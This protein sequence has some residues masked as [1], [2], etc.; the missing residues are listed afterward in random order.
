MPKKKNVDLEKQ[1]TL[2]MAQSLYD[3]L[4]KTAPALGIDP[5]GLIRM[6]L[7]QNLPRYEKMAHEAEGLPCE[8]E[9][10]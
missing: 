10:G 6:I 4:V 3:R 7:L 5:T 8:Q 1:L 9:K 2:R